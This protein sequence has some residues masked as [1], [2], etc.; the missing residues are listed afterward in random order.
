MVGLLVEHFQLDGLLNVQFRS[1]AV[2]PEWPQ[3][4]EINGRMSGGLPYIGL[5]GLNL[6]LLA[7]QFALHR[8]GEPLPII[9]E[10]VLPLRAQE[11]SEVFVVPALP[12]RVQPNSAND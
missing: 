7:V 1:S 11:R 9:P 10:P 12:T 3:L 5:T 6:P 4:L 2:Q 8:P